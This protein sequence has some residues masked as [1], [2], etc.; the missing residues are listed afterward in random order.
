M[1]F[2]LLQI[3][4]SLPSEI[5]KLKYKPLTAASPEL[6]TVDAPLRFAD[7]TFYLFLRINKQRNSSESL[8]NSS[9]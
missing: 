4:D 1:I 9:V 6:Y 2:K 5:F 8:S 3:V 7:H